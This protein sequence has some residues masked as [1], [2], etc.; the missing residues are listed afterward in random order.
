MKNEELYYGFDSETQKKHEQTLVE[1]GIVSQ[2][3]LDDSHQKLKDWSDQDKN[4]YLMQG[5][6][7]MSELILAIEDGKPVDHKSVQTTMKKH[8]QWLSQSW[9]PSK[10]K[11]LG[12]SEL[13]QSDGFAE[14]FTQ[15]HPKLLSFIVQAMKV[16]AEKSLS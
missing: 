7:I 6:K 5:E 3:M 13:Y 4:N 16:Y 1:K 14:F 10:E 11:Y 2:E 9:T 15:R 12:L 8:Y